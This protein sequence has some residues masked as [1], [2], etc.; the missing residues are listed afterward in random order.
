MVTGVSKF[1][2]HK[3]ITRSAMPFAEPDKASNGQSE[4]FKS[5]MPSV[6][7]NTS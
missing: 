7:S 3:M 5:E 1:I 4:D 2:E 6:P